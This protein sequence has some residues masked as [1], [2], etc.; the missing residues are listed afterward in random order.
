MSINKH[1][2]LLRTLNEKNLKYQNL[3]EENGERE[4]QVTSI[5]PKKHQD[6]NASEFSDFSFSGFQI[7]AKHL[8]ALNTIQN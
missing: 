7:S 3:D 6:E 1:I 5:K 8:H 4:K 2:G